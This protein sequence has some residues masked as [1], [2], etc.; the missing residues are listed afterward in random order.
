MHQDCAFSMLLFHHGC[1]RICTVMSKY[2]VGGRDGEVSKVG[3]IEAAVEVSPDS[4]LGEH[5][6]TLR[7]P[8]TTTFTSLLYTDTDGRSAFATLIRIC[9]SLLPHAYVLHLNRDGFWR[10]VI[11]AKTI[12]VA[13]Q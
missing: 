3:N 2:K 6:A 12:L 4:M 7:R 1:A 5:N 10:D 13:L 8:T 9:W 11:L